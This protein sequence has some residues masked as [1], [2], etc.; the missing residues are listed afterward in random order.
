M[1]I[2]LALTLVLAASFA[3]AVPAGRS[4]VVV[5]PSAKI[6]A[7]LVS[8]VADLKTVTRT[9]G[10]TPLEQKRVL[11]QGA[12]LLQI[13][14]S[15]AVVP[16]SDKLY[17]MQVS[18]G[19][20][21]VVGPLD[22]LVIPVEGGG[23]VKKGLG[24]HV[25]KELLAAVRRLEGKTE[26]KGVAEK[27]SVLR[28][29]FD[30]HEFYTHGN[31]GVTSVIG[32][33]GQQRADLIAGGRPGGVVWQNRRADGRRA[34]W[35][36]SG[37][38]REFQRL[39]MPSGYAGYYFAVR[40]LNEGLFLQ[41]AKKDGGY[42]LGLLE[43]EEGRFTVYPGFPNHSLIR[44][45]AT[46]D[47]GQITWMDRNVLTRYKPKSGRTFRKD[48]SALAAK[49][50]KKHP[51]VFLRDATAEGDRLLA[52]GDD[53]MGIVD[54]ATERVIAQR[55][56]DFDYDQAGD[57][58]DSARFTELGTLVFIDRIDGPNQ[59]WDFRSDELKDL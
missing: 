14:E 30:G 23:K 1:R 34:L 17:L 21:S 44:A 27:L 24:T 18:I 11:R 3:H 26:A 32:L 19:H 58:A 57:A 54:A 7:Y 25:E 50:A 42:D 31:P 22:G 5:T 55:K 53:W 48:F 4:R 51:G 6:P 9:L 16:T 40:T 43:P 59:T 47:A 28:E 12:K 33:E 37:E 41:L 36:L 49:L 39:K 20:P 45:K 15:L 29:M 10:Y 8:G 35:S 2:P 38:D 46:L 56:M 52:T 13:G